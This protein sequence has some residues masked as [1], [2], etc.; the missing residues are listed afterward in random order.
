MDICIHCVIM[1]SSRL[2]SKNLTVWKK[3]P[4]SKSTECGVEKCF[5]FA[6]HLLS[7]YIVWFNEKNITATP[8][9]I[10][11][12]CIAYIYLYSCF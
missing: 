12:K 7:V 8:G 11:N 3:T 10:K 4:V 2:S 5:Q 1:F 6:V 9:I